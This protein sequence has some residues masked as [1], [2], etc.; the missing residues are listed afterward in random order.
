MYLHRFIEND[1]LKWKNESNKVLILSGAR[2]VGK[3]T[4]LKHFSEENYTNVVYLDASKPLGKSLEQYYVER[5]SHGDNYHEFLKEFCE[6]NNLTFSN[7]KSTILILDEIQESKPLYE[8][9]RV[10]NREYDCDVIVTGSYLG[11]ISNY[12]QPV[13]DVERLTMFPI[14]YLEFLSYFN[15]Y[16]FLKDSYKDLGDKYEFYVQ[17]YN[18]YNQLGGYPDIV[19]EYI[20]NGNVI[21]VEHLKK[22]QAGIIQLL[23]DEIQV[24]TDIF[25]RNKVEAVLNS[26]VVM[27]AKEKQGSRRS[28][29]QLSKITTH[30]A[31]FSV[32]TN[33]YNA[34]L[35]WLQTSGFISLISKYDFE[36]EFTYPQERIYVC[37]IGILSYF[38]DKSTLDESTKS[39]IVAEN[40]VYCNLRNKET[41]GILNN[42]ISFGVKDKGELDFVC[43]S[44]WD[45][46]VYG[47]EVKTGKNKGATIS[48]LL[49]EG[50]IDYAIYFKENAKYGKSGN[51]VTVPLFAAGVYDFREGTR[52]SLYNTCT[53]ASL[54]AFE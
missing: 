1:L 5:C 15:A 45:S 7:D 52:S 29:E 49:S 41:E 8:A 42:S 26:I 28:I 22:L 20:S 3:T 31:D 48:D 35:T 37:D 23:L 46:C 39:G 9:I 38:L 50:D 13:G 34:T 17:A 51:V 36:T 16:E 47:V 33:E 21:T 4:V 30:T 12:F 25:D 2:Q 53:I 10:F 24:R 43:M 11:R 44:T 14:S 18:V 19:H 6:E 40:F 27:M 32:S 54:S